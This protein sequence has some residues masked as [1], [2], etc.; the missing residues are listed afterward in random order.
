MSASEAQTN[1]H[2]WHEIWALEKI[3]VEIECP[4]CAYKFR[5]D[6]TLPDKPKH[7]A[8]WYTDQLNRNRQW[9]QELK[10]PGGCIPELLQMGAIQKAEIALDRWEERVAAEAKLAGLSAMEDKSV[11]LRMAQQ[12]FHDWEAHDRLVKEKAEAEEALS[13][14]PPA[15]DLKELEEKFVA[16]RVY[17]S[18]LEQYKK[19]AADYLEKMAKATALVEEATDF[20]S[21]ATALAEARRELKA[22]L[23]PSLSRVASSLISEMTCGK[24]DA[25]MVDEN[26]TVT[27]NGQ[28]A[29]TLSG[30]GETAANLALRLALGRTLVGG[31][32]PVFLGDEI[33]ADADEERSEAMFECVRNL[34]GQFQQVI[35]VTHKPHVSADHVID[36]DA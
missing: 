28:A 24:L 18:Q 17:E 33:D 26:M 36:F 15:K 35:I 30:A 31:V 19:N 20:M 9:S 34:R 10:N 29:E 3:N 21:G 14:L 7:P 23:A 22:Y 11:E 1:L 25:V 12:T 16:A 2:I 27:V 6:K 5:P 32:F 4:E 8:D 13:K